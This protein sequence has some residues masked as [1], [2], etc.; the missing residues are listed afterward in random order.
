MDK[1]DFKILELHNEVRQQ[2]M[3]KEEEDLK[4]QFINV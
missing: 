2:Q 3:C 1:K 4:Q